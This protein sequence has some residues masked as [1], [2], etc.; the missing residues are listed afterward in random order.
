MLK[1]IFI[2]SLGLLLLLGVWEGAAHIFPHLLFILPAPTKIFATLIEARQRLLFHTFVTLKEMAGGFALAISLSFPLAWT[3]VRYRGSR[4][5]LEPFFLI[6]QCLPMFT[7]APLMIIWFGWSFTAIVVP[8]ALMIF[9]PLTLN[10]YQGLRSTPES[11]LE[12]FGSNQATRW[13]I[14]FKLQLPWAVPHIFAGFRIAAGI[15]GV[16]A[17][18]GEWA[19]AQQG[20]GILMI[21]SR[22]DTDLEVTFGALICLT[23]MTGLLYG[24]ILLLE[25]LAL[26][27]R[28]WKSFKP[29]KAVALLLASCLLV[30][31]CTKR[32][33][34]ET[35]LLL[36]WLPNPH[37]IPLYV[38]LSKGFFEEEGIDLKIHK[39]REHGGGIAYLTAHQADLLLY[40]MPGGFRAVSRGANLKLVASLIKQPLRAFI[41]LNGKGI[42]KKDDLSNKVL[43]YCIPGSDTT[44]LDFLLFEAG[45]EPAAKRNVSVDIVSSIGMQNVDCIYGAFWNSEP[46]QL[47]A[48]GVD[49]DYFKIEEFDVPS[50]YELVLFADGGTKEASAPFGL[51]FRR[52]FQRSINWCKEHP[53]EAFTIYLKAN[54]D[55][56]KKTLTWER[57]VWEITLPL[58]AQD[59]SIDEELLAQFYQWQEERGFYKKSFDFHQLLPYAGRNG[60]LCQDSGYREG[61]G[62]A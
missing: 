61:V 33:K 57:K 38:G 24:L 44:F 50:Y 5:I 15:A 26:P 21:E 58:L 54:P 43:G 28:P 53:E 11:L 56:R 10:I 60:E 1:R 6:L 40:H 37:H 31:G 2:S 46:Y 22:R 42:K 45:I 51:A 23:V 55:K 30:T 47:E 25:N 36:D 62:G 52:A 34:S 17:I 3:M 48:L 59:Q 27:P 39:M 9:F 14:F 8:T 41:Y 4:A 12:F 49:V 16:G 19:G 13:Q 32:S 29:L 18:A 7:L 20:L 35:R